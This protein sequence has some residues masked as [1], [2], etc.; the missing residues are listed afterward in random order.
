M[1]VKCPTCGTEREIK[2]TEERV[3][4]ANKK[5]CGKRYYVKNNTVPKK[6]T[7]GDRKGQKTTKNLRFFNRDKSLLSLIIMANYAIN[8]IKNKQDVKNKKGTYYDYYVS[9]S[10]WREFFRMFIKMNK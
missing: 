3:R 7:E 10:E 8:T 9:W 4:C 1:K 2:G 6:R 5:D